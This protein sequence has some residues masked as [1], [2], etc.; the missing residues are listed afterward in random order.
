MN[1]EIFYRDELIALRALV[2]E[3]IARV[4]ATNFLHLVVLGGL[5]Q[6]LERAIARA[7]SAPSARTPEGTT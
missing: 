2:H 3:A 5:D 4:D 1:D 6:K 7:P